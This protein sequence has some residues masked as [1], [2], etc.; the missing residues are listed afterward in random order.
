[1]FTPLVV[2]IPVGGRCEQVSSTAQ[3]CVGLV[4]SVMS[5]SGVQGGE[6]GRWVG[7]VSAACR[8]RCVGAFRCGFPTCL[9]DRKLG[10][11]LAYAHLDSELT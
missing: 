1:M 2:F 10:L 3:T 5:A 8:R 11:S 9:V 4:K 7:D 6:D